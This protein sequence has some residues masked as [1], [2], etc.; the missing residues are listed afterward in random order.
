MSGSLASSNQSELALSRFWAFN[1]SLSVD[2]LPLFLDVV[3]SAPVIIPFDATASTG[4][5]SLID[6]TQ[7]STAS[8]PPPISCYP[9]LNNTQ[10]TALEVF[11]SSVFGLPPAQF[12]STKVL[13]ASCFPDRP[14]YGVLNLL[15]LRTPFLDGR[16]GFAK[17]AVVVNEDVKT[18]V[19][20]HAQELFAGLPGGSLPEGGASTADLDPR[21]HGTILHLNH[22][23]LA[24]LQAMP[25]LAFARD[26]VAFV[27]SPR[28][29]NSSLPL[30]LPPSNTSSLAS[31]VL[32]A[33]P[34]IEV[35]L[36]G[37]ILI[38][39][40]NYTLS[41]FSTPSSSLFFGTSNSNTFRLWAVQSP[42]TSSISPSV[43]W[44][45]GAT[46]ERVVVQQTSSDETF[47]KVFNG[48][49]KVVATGVDTTGG[50]EVREVVRELG[51]GGLLVL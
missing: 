1:L 5:Q 51:E 39:T 19:T 37:S 24:F 12:G 34:T 35:A 40:V 48:A 2:Q 18:R 45:E 43:V 25:S 8:F 11:E 30:P 47:E 50:E 41:S 36:H 33:L 4:S 22:V 17:Q 28:P 3:R 49:L 31:P 46:S 16:T 32:A 38:S 20:L 26:F 13:T 15:H 7:M 6:L 21:E 14:V 29:F 9:N 42:K 23:V 27:L 10:R 44:A